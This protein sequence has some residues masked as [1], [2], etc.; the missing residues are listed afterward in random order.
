MFSLG[1]TVGDKMQRAD[2]VARTRLA[3]E[4]NHSCV[5]RETVP[6]I[7]RTIV[8]CVFER[9]FSSL[10]LVLCSSEGVAFSKGC[11]LN[12]NHCLL[13]LLG[14]I[15]WSLESVLRSVKGVPIAGTTVC[16]GAYPSLE[17]VLRSVKDVPIHFQTRRFLCL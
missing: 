5:Q 10:E 12:Q 6:P 16:E 15:P 2:G 14:S 4:Q 17:T 7:S 13:C 9:A 11:A 8:Y 3:N 1:A